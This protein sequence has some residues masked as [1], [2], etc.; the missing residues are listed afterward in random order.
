MFLTI[1]LSNFS[2]IS[3]NA[4]VVDGHDVQA[5]I[6]AFDQAK[7]CTDRPTALIAKT[8]KGFAFDNAADGVSD[9]MGWHG[10]PLGA[11][12]E[13]I[14]AKIKAS[15]NMEAFI[16]PPKPSDSLSE[17]DTSPIKLSGPP[18]YNIGDKVC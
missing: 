4:I 12:G 5:V 6:N 2:F 11:K 13:E 17:A 9:L 8:F 18:A 10:K 3:W 15:T 7:A 14:V 1:F 16:A